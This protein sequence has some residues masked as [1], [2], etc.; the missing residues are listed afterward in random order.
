ME[1]LTGTLRD[2]LVVG[3]MFVL[4]IG[5]PILITLMIGAW[6]QRLLQ[7]PETETQPSPADLANG[8]HCWDVNKCEETKRAQC[9]AFQRPD[10][11]CWLAIQV[12][13]QGLTEKCYSCALFTQR[14]AAPA[15]TQA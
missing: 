5:V 1:N 3:Y 12:S 6:L 7:E 10:L 2:V 9:A 4:R 14:G 13:G 11:P 8:K 15:H